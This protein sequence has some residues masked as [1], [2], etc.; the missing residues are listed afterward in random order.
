MIS[1]PY[2]QFDRMVDQFMMSN[3]NILKYT[4]GTFFLTFSIYVL[5]KK[6]V[7]NVFHVTK[8]TTF[9]TV[10]IAVVLQ[11]LLWMPFFLD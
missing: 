1:I 4:V 2:H 8:A 9:W 11:A 7:K 5:F 6:K 3:V 10:L